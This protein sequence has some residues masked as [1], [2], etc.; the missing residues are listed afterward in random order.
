MRTPRPAPLEKLPPGPRAP[1]LWQLGRWLHDPIGLMEEC[2]RRHGDAFTLD[3]WKVGRRC[4]YFSAPAAVREIFTASPAR[5]Q[6]GES[7]AIL[8]P[9]VGRTS[10]F[11]LDGAR[12]DH[13]RRLLMPP[14]HGERMR[15]YFRVI[16]DALDAEVDTWSPAAPVTFQTAMGRVTLD[17]MLRAVF[18]LRQPAAIERFRSTF[19]RLARD[20]SSPWLLVRALQVDLGPRSP[21][22]RVV[23]FKEE[24]DAFLRQELAA[25]RRSGGEGREDV[26]ALLVAARDEHG[27]PMT[28]EELRDQLVTLLLAGHE[29]TATQLAWTLD[30]ILRRP[31]LLAR[32]RAELREVTGGAELAA[33]HLPQLRLLDATLHESMRLTPTVANTV[34]VLRQPTRIGGWDLP[35]G[36]EVV[37]CIHLTHRRA[38]VW[39]DPE[40]FDPDRFL[41]RKPGPYELYPFGGGGRRCVGMAFALYEMRVVMARLLSRVEL[42]AAAGPAP[43]P[44]RRGVTIA[45]AGGVSVQIVGRAG[46]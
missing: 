46:G 13:Q 38:D 36:V 14:F 23:R 27:E 45:P 25:C 41:A 21:W 40:T 29:T 37:P 26:L 24:F 10:V 15:A 42:A 8:E 35:A 28:D 11:L 17:V 19:A 18:G 5:L 44:I 22:G 7:N 1:A 16:R 20:A 34:R 43:R 33:D 30:A 12:H 32:L 9:F 39:P 4:V 6:G 31:P 3:L 2:G